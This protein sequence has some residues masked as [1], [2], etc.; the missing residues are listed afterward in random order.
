MAAGLGA[1]HDQDI[2]AGRDLAQ[3][4]LLG[5]DQRRD[6]NAVLLAHVDH[7]LRRHAKR[8]G[9]QPDRVTER[10]LEHLQRALP[11]ERLRLVVGDV[12]RR[13]FDAVFFQ[14]VAGEVRGARATSAP[15]GFS[16]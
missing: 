8:V 12:R 2:D 5:A 7:R 6:G 15:P 3:R 13:Q 4:M 14:E 9:D 11:I 1:L 16:R 10:R